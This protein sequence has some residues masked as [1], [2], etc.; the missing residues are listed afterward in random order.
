MSGELALSQLFPL[1]VRIGP[2]DVTGYLADGMTFS[3]VD[4]GGYEMA[5]FQI[6]KDLPNTLRGM[7]IRIDCGLKVAWQGRIS[8]LQ[9]SLGNETTITGEGDAARLRDNVLAQIF[10]DRDLTAWLGPSV[11][12]QINDVTA[13]YSPAAGQV[14]P[15]AT[16]GNPSIVLSATGP[17][18]ANGY[19]TVEA[20]YDAQGVPIQSVIYTADFGAN[21]TAA[22]FGAA[23]YLST[24][25][26]LSTTDSNSFSGNTTGTLTAGAGNRVYGV[27]QA[28]GP[29]TPGGTNNAQYVIY[30][31]NLAVY[32]NHGLTKRGSSPGGFYAS[33]IA[34]YIAGLVPNIQPGIIQTA[35]QYI[36]PHS[37][38]KTPVTLDQIVGDM[39]LAAGWHWGVWESL[40]PLTGKREPRFDFRP[41][42]QQGQWSAFCHRSDCDTVDITEDLSNQYDTA[43]ITYNDVSGVSRQVTVTQA[44]PILDI[45]GIHRTVQFNGG[46]MTAATA[47]VFGLQALS[48]LYTQGRVAGTVTISGPIDGPAPAWL[49]KAGIDRLR[50]GDIPSLDAWGTLNDFPISRVE[51]TGG[52]DGFKTMIELGSGGNLVETLQSRLSAASVM[53]AQGGV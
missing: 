28:L 44:N 2:D 20:L 13:G 36:I 14:A 35:S 5:S 23:V 24:D 21:A 10:V 43:V 51:T 53:A 47:S 52:T 42:P 48:L 46:T 41:R 40:T 8:Q 22:S 32:G 50:I 31:S 16:T 4:P 15:D 25:D 37:V 34:A 27:L 11:Q 19:V 30:F 7:P 1:R 33:D 26:V 29:N 39:A 12:R 3:N 45:A 49:L 17:W 6:P 38:Y 18:A 9:R